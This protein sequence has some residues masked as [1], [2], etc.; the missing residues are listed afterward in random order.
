[1]KTERRRNC[2]FSTTEKLFP[3]R[4]R[5]LLITS[6]EIRSL[7]FTYLVIPSLLELE[8]GTNS[9]PKN[10]GKLVQIIAV[11]T[12]KDFNPCTSHLTSIV[13]LQKVDIQHVMLTDRLASQQR[14]WLPLRLL[15]LKIHFM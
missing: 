11:H 5:V 8:W 14:C 12:Q 6:I 3:G 10:E 1:M 4:Y 7:C 9:W 13:L 2:F 15:N